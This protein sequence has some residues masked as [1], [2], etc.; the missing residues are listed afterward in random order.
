L[1]LDTNEGNVLATL[2]PV[3]GYNKASN[4]NSGRLSGTRIPVDVQ[5]GGLLTWLGR[6]ENAECIKVI[7]PSRP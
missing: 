4:I 6:P 1:T 5:E 2:N 3:G 7:Q